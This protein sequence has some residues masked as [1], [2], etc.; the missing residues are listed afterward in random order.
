MEG[1][2]HSTKKVLTER[3]KLISMFLGVDYR[4]NGYS[5]S[6]KIATGSEYA[7]QEC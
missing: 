7:N 3:N 5:P 1:F 2:E 4:P 6:P